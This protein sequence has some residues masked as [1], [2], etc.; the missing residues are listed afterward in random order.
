MPKPT[1]TEG[2]IETLRRERRQLER[3]VFEFERGPAGQFAPSPRL[4]LTEAQL[5]GPTGDGAG[6][7]ADDLRA[8]VA[9]EAASLAWLKA[10]LARRRV[11]ALPGAGARPG[12]RRALTRVL[13]DF[14]LPPEALFSAL[15]R[16]GPGDVFGRER[17]RW[18]G[19]RSLADHLH[20]QLVQ[21]YR[22]AKRRART[23]SRSTAGPRRGKDRLL[24]D[25]ERE[26]RLLAQT[27]TGLSAAALNTP[28]VVAQWSVKD[29]LAHLTA[30]EQMFLGWYRAGQR[31]ETPA[32]PAPGYT[33]RDLDALNDSLFRRSRRRKPAAVLTDFALSYAQVLGA[34]TAMPE[35]DL[36]APG[37]YAWLGGGNLYGYI[38]ANSSHHYRW[39]RG[40][41]RR[42]RTA[43]AS[44]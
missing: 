15:A 11:P 41:I 23:L 31:G 2:L 32:V 37:R 7:L 4:K 40:L 24:A 36:L 5:T 34:V 22:A 17:Y 18:T 42:W 21:R 14:R 25:I 33:W 28:G 16:L 19:G 30:W 3:Y 38:Q 26:H 29:V 20:E 39:A 8:I 35:A 13:A 43:H 27:I 44:V 6:P 12:R 1:T 10:G 9:A